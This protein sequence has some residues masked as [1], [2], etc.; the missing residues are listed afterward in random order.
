MKAH[1]SD[2][3]TMHKLCIIISLLQSVSFKGAVSE[4]RS[5]TRL[6]LRIFIQCTSV[7]K[8]GIINSLLQS[9]SFE[10]AV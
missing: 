3:H 6:I 2:F 1:S 8:L 10:G 4:G 5:A 9:V 7:H